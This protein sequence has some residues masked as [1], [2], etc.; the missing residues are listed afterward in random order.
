MTRSRDTLF[1]WTYDEWDRAAGYYN[2]C[3]PEA[4]I[5][6]MPMSYVAISLIGSRDGSVRPLNLDDHLRVMDFWRERRNDEPV[7]SGILIAETYRVRSDV[8]VTAPR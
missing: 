3:H 8:C 5:R 4:P 2:L 7:D 1:G 6:L